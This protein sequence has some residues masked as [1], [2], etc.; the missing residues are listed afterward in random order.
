MLPL[1]DGAAPAVTASYAAGYRAAAELENY[2]RIMRHIEALQAGGQAPGE[3][4]LF[5]ANI[6]S[7]TRTL[8]RVQSAAVLASDDGR[9]VKQTVR[10]TLGSRLQ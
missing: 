2:T 5:G 10:Y 1:L 4:P 6:A 7:L 9:S 8:Q 3:P